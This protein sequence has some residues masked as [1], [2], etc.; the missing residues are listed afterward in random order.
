VKTCASAI[1]CGRKRQI[2]GAPGPAFGTG[3][4]TMPDRTLKGHSFK[5]C[6]NPNSEGLCNRARLGVPGYRGA[7]WAGSG[8]RA[9][10]PQKRMSGLYSLRKNSIRRGLCIRA[11]LQS[12][13]KCRLINEGFSPGGDAGLANWVHP[14]TPLPSFAGGR[15][16]RNSRLIEQGRWPAHQPGKIT[17]SHEKLCPV[18]RGFIAMSGRV[19]QA[20]ILGPETANPIN[21]PSLDLSCQIWHIHD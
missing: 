7:L 20:W 5:S 8:S 18:H 2:L 11:R 21:P 12:S 6:G 10:T 9:A 17:M 1:C 4:T 19:P 3:N 13:R 14:S 15:E 16:R